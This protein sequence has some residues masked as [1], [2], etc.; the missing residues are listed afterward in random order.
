[1]SEVKLRWKGYC[2]N[3]WGGGR[4]EGN[5]NWG[6]AE[7]IFPVAQQE[8]A[9]QGP[10]RLTPVEDRTWWGEG[11]TLLPLWVPDSV[12]SSSMDIH[13]SSHPR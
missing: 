1:M 13:C 3:R 5:G 7:L 6:Q 11:L 2:G 8:P 10:R 4:E 9:L 12:A